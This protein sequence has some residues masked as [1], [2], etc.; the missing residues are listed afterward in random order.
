MTVTR[1]PITSELDIALEQLLRGR[2]HVAS[3]LASDFRDAEVARSYE[4]EARLWSVLF[5]QAEYRLIWRAALAAEAHA[6][7]W[8]EYW[9]DRAADWSLVDATAELGGAA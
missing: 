4:L 5:E 7:F 1:V 6:R 2:E 9:R 3:W 8:A